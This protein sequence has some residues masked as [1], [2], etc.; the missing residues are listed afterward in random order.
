MASFSLISLLVERLTCQLFNKETCQGRTWQ[1]SPSTRANK[2]CQ[3]ENLFVWTTLKYCTV[4]LCWCLQECVHKLQKLRQM[5]HVP[6]RLPSPCTSEIDGDVTP[7][8]SRS[9]GPG[10]AQVGEGGKNAWITISDD[11]TA[12]EKAVAMETE[13]SA[14]AVNE[15]PSKA[16][17]GGHWNAYVNSVWLWRLICGETSRFRSPIKLI[18]DFW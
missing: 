10:T 14:T 18:L 5:S 4:W 6:G 9:Q 12:D 15:A 16:R 13:E 1:I 2:T 7:L 8:L 11:D 17:T 3:G